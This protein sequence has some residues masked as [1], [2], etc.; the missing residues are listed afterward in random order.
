MY[1]AA[2]SPGKVTMVKPNGLLSHTHAVNQPDPLA[3]VVD[4]AVGIMLVFR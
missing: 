3:I 1:R 4:F 2:S